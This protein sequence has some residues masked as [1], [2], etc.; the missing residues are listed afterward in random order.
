[1]GIEKWNEVDHLMD[2]AQEENIKALHHRYNALLR[3]NKS[4]DSAPSQKFWKGWSAL[5]IL[6]FT[7]WG[8]DSLWLDGKH[9]VEL[10]PLNTEDLKV[11]SPFR[12]G[13]SRQQLHNHWQN[14]LQVQLQ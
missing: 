4:F 6:V 14:T 7:L 3:I 12:Y 11:E 8:K 10:P 13:A 1:M 9:F 2:P 5:L